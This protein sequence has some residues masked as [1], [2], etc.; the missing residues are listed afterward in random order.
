MPNATKEVALQKKM[1]DHFLSPAP[2]R[3]QKQIR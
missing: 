3:A 2:A 1:I